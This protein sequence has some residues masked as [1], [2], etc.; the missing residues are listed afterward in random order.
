MVLD[1]QDQD[2]AA[3]VAG[4]SKDPAPLAFDLHDHRKSGDPLRNR[5]ES[6]C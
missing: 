5:Y 3:L 1:L 6:L 4:S 2:S